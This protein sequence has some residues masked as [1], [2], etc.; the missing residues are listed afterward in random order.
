[1]ALTEQQID[2][3]IEE[4]L[5]VKEG[6]TKEGK[7]RAKIDDFDQVVT[8][9]NQE[10]THKETGKSLVSDTEIAKLVDLPDNNTLNATLGERPTGD[11]TPEDHPSSATT[12]VISGDKNANRG[13][14][15]FPNAN[16][17]NPSLDF[18]EIASGETAEHWFLNNSGAT[19]TI[20]LP[21]CKVSAGS[22]TAT[23]Y[24]S[25]GGTITIDTGEEL[26][27]FVEHNSVGYR[28]TFEKW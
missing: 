26:K 9:L 12:I 1:M 22:A 13:K 7:V 23:Y 15:T 27:L 10:K 17:D 28:V 16:T 25:V 4:K 14:T 24:D 21:A 11:S 19:R 2:A 20:T 3:L 18:T 6:G 8:A 5:R